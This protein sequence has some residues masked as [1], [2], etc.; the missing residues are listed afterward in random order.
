LVNG[1]FFSLSSEN[2]TTLGDGTLSVADVSH[3]SVANGAIARH[4]HRNIPLQINGFKVV[5]VGLDSL[6]AFGT[7]FAYKT[8]ADFGRTFESV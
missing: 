2:D 5:F 4:D 1:A 8:H 7:L 6:S 3:D